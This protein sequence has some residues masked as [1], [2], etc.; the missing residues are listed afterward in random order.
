MHVYTHLPVKVVAGSERAGIMTEERKKC[1][2]SSYH[3]ER[4]EVGETGQGMKYYIIIGYVV[5][6]DS[7][8]YTF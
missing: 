4:K 8:T 7:S 2:L 5:T 3:V 6:H 1:F